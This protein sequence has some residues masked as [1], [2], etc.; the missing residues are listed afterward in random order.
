MKRSRHF[1][2]KEISLKIRT[3]LESAGG[4]YEEWSGR[5]RLNA[6]LG[7]DSL[8]QVEAVVMIEKHYGIEIPDEVL[9]NVVTVTDLEIAVSRELKIREPKE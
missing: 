8:D 2:I 4:R 7:L 6:D 1:S 5:G 3:F 9:D